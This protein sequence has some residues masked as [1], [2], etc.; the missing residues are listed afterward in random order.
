VANDSKSA[1]LKT[2]DIKKTLS[3]QANTIEYMLFTLY[4]APDS[5]GRQYP[6]AAGKVSKRTNVNREENS[7]I[8]SDAEIISAEKTEISLKDKSESD[9]KSETKETKEE[10]KKVPAWIGLA[11]LIVIAGIIIYII[12]FLG[13]K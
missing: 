4:S 2:D 1:A 11:G 8:K 10:N 3:M 12:G 7:N 5:S 13:R 6:V 9:S